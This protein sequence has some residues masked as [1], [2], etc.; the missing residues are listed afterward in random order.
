MN[1]CWSN[2]NISSRCI[3]A[4]SGTAAVCIAL[5][6]CGVP[7][8]DL[9]K[10]L[11]SGVIAPPALPASP[12]PSPS[13][14]DSQSVAPSPTVTSDPVELWFAGDAGLVPVLT[15]VEPANSAEAVVAGLVAGPPEDEQLRTVAVDPLTG[16]PLISVFLDE[17]TESVNPGDVNIALSPEFAAL[18][19]NE[20]VLV[21]GQLV[22]SIAGEGLG[23]VAFVDQTGSPVA[24]PLPDG[25]L[26]DRPATVE[27]YRSLIA[28]PGAN[29]A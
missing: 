15:A 20:Q 19:P 27:D 11:A 16:L 4:W 9:A 28:R 17:V 18:P 3:V 24:V 10:P 26:L 23:T 8:Q 2:R 29:L 14:T 5:V 21:L 7:T 22:L 1:R 12:S 13:P 25:R 6:S